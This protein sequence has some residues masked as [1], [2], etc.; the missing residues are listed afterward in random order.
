MCHWASH[1]ILLKRHSRQH[2]IFEINSFCSLLL[3]YTLYTL[4]AGRGRSVCV[5]VQRHVH[6]L[7]GIA[8]G[9]TGEAR[10][11]L[12]YSI[13]CSSDFACQIV[14]GAFTFCPYISVAKCVSQRKCVFCVSVNLR[15]ASVVLF[16][17][18]ARCTV[19]MSGLLL[20]ADTR[21]EA[22]SSSSSMMVT[23]GVGM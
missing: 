10:V 1:G 11:P 5:A 7:Y 14:C 4:L 12:R 6:R 20:M 15:L 19:C 23:M 22:S 21:W 18:V 2:N 17:F 13:V 8:P 16:A 3:L 9:P